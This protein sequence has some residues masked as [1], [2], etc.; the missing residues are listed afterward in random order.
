MTDDLTDDDLVQRIQ[1][2]LSEIFAADGG[3]LVSKFILVAEVLSDHGRE[4]AAVP[5]EDVTPWDRIGML[6]YAE[7][8]MG[9]GDDEPEAEG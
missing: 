8:F 9:E 6:S 5:S 7:T 3:R 2:A 1:Q 4:F